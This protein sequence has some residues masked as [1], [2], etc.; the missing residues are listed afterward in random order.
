MNSLENNIGYNFIHKEL[1]KEALTHPS[2]LKHKRNSH[3]KSYERL[4]FLGDSVLGL[5]V[6]EMLIK[7]FQHENEGELARRHANLVNGASVAKIAL[8]LGVE[9]FI[10]MSEGER[11]TGGMENAANLEDAMEAIIGAIYLDGGF[12]SAKTVVSNLWLPL[13]SAVNAPPKDPKSALQEWAQG[14]GLPLPIYTVIAEEGPAHL[15][16]FTINVKIDGKG[17][18][19]AI[20]KSKKL[21]ELSDAGKLFTS[22]TNSKIESDLP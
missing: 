4:E 20:G 16:V 17:E 3:L 5:I 13:L 2:V 12:E 7:H 22:L 9:A 1:L 15:P 18:E 8:Q 6:A 14:R 19:T 11:Q 21:A 10:D